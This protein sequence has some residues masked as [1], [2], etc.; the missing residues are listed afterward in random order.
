MNQNKRLEVLESLIESGLQK[1]GGS[2]AESEAEPQRVNQRPSGVH[3][4]R[5]RLP[6]SAKSACP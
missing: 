5:I 6:P 2:L 1:A 3:H 4:L